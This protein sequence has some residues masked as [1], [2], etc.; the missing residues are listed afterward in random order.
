M[1]NDKLYKH[2]YPL[3]TE[4]E[5]NDFLNSQYAE[6]YK[7]VGNLCRCTKNEISAI[8][9][10]YISKMKPTVSYLGTLKKKNIAHNKYIVYMM[11]KDISCIEK[12]DS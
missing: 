6:I 10:D 3:K 8:K 2:Y 5:K 9:N 12:K 11:Y 7:E 1:L 4:E